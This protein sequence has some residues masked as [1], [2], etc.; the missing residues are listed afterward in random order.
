MIKYISDYH[1]FKV[2]NNYYLFN[3]EMMS[4]FRIT[5]SL[6]I[7]LKDYQPYNKINVDIVPQNII[8][9]LEKLGIIEDALP[10]KVVKINPEIS[11]VA[12]ISLNIAQLCNLNCIYCYGIDGEYGE[13][14]YMN[15]QTAFK[16]VD[17]L[18]KQS[19]DR[20]NISIVFFGG[21]PLLNFSLI[22]DVV[23]YATTQS[24]KANKKIH[25]SITTNGTKFNKEI[26]KFLNKH[27]FGVVISFDGT[28]EMQNA[29]RPFK[30]GKGSYDYIRTKIENFIR[31]RKGEGII[32]RA[33]ITN[34]NTNL[35]KIYDELIKIGFKNIYTAVVSAPTNKDYQIQKNDIINILKD[36]KLQ[37]LETI[38]AI[39][40]KNQIYNKRFI[41]ILKYLITKKKKHY[42]CG[43]GR[44][45]VGISISGDIYPCHRF[46]GDKTML[47]GNI[48]NFNTQNNIINIQNSELSNSQCNDCWARYFCGGGCIYENLQYNKTK[49]VSNDYWCQELKYRVELSIYIYDQLNKDDKEYLFENYIKRK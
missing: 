19:L 18:I 4:A 31:M 48:F 47:I 43:A 28:K 15:K 3:T 12:S 32:G 13:K 1:T 41:E 44:N 35:K 40:E 6:F 23:K 33:T 11:P 39:K 9:A 38:K 29:N 49:F 27:E 25:F 5:K 30:G 7:A 22:K 46:V 14:G 2:M 37:A 36:L 45:M 26:N 8:N 10:K 20:K 17:W 21:E 34:R 16:A 42:F 24:K